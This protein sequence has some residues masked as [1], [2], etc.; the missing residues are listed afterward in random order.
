MLSLP[1]TFRFHVVV[2]GVLD[3]LK[4]FKEFN[5][6]LQP[7]SCNI[8]RA[9]KLRDAFATRLDDLVLRQDAPDG[10]K[11]SAHMSAALKWWRKQLATCDSEEPAIV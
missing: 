4:A 10:K 2:S 9:A 1:S 11:P 8:W 5:D 6:A 3:I 7:V